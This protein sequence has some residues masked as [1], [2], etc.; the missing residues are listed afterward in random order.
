MIKQIFKR[1]RGYQTFF[2]VFILT[3]MLLV[4]ALSYVTYNPVDP[5]W[6]S[7]NSDVVPCTNWCGPLGA[8][9]A[10]LLFYFF[11][12]SCFMLLVAMLSTLYIV[13]HQRWRYDWDR[14][15]ACLVLLCIC[16]T[17]SAL[18]GVD[19]SISPYPGGFIGLWCSTML[20]ARC[21]LFTT[22]VILYALLCMSI[23]IMVR[24][25]WVRSCTAIM[26][27]MP[28]SYD[29]V[30]RCGALLKSYI[31]VSRKKY[32]QVAT[33]AYSWM[34]QLLKS[35]KEPAVSLPYELHEDAPSIHADAIWDALR[36]SSSVA[37]SCDT[38]PQVMCDD[39]STMQVSSY[40]L[41]PRTLFTY[42]Q[43]EQSQAHA[44]QEAELRARILEQKLEHF[45]VTGSVVSIKCGPVVTL[46]EYKPDVDTKLSKIIALEDDLA[47]A[48]QALSI[49]ILAPIPGKSVVGFEIA[50]EHRMS[51]L[52][53]QAVHSSAYTNFKGLLPLLLG[54]D[55]QGQHVVVDLATM[56]HLL[57]AGSTG[58]GKSVALHAMIMSL[59]C[60][61]TPQELRVMLIDPKR[62]EFA[63]YT[64]IPHLLFPI[65]TN[66]QQAAPYLQWIVHEM[67]SRYSAMAH[68]G[69]RTIAEYNNKV[70][71]TQTKPYI[72]VIIDELADLMMTAGRDVETT[73]ARI[74]QMARAAGI[75]MIVATQRPSVD[76]ITGL[77]K[78]NF[79]SRISFRV[80]SKI[81]SRTILDCAGAD[82][83]LGKGD[84]LV[85]DAADATLKRVHGA[86]VTD[87]QITAVVHHI[88][89]QQ[90]VDYI[91]I[92]QVQQTVTVQD[93]E[94][95]LYD[96]I[97]QFLGEIDEVSI[98]LLQR[99][100]RIGYNRSARIIELLEARGLLLPSDGGK[101]R[102]VVR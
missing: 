49:R 16:A 33:T 99:K 72:V 62:L 28:L 36:T 45:G 6:V 66:P 84:M 39:A 18:Y 92:K 32:G 77:I 79:P 61:K 11:G 85:S 29:R 55:T 88:R 54:Q 59:L 13:W 71:A 8:N 40:T 34:P 98:S 86:Y 90:Q 58:S 41:P 101:T 89:A 81:D 10:A 5:S 52:F 56:P 60:K 37:S 20:R 24:F 23:L 63:A 74:T 43:Q 97:I 19:S 87:Q 35:D 68:E 22:L 42:Q 46:F 100:F 70:E 38:Q 31:T 95:P 12:G 15:V 94:D 80:T 9:L 21:D 65:I 2:V 73:I 96:Q 25:S 76:V 14:V 30:A 48:L 93:Y 57:V 17:L 78:V 50:N 67:E 102:K 3:F 91:D 44:T 47:L 1:V 51:V 27:H 64:D 26:R 4:V 7:Y 82:K 69:V 53:S 83:L 75:H